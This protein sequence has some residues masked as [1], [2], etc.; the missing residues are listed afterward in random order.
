LVFLFSGISGY[1]SPVSIDKEQEQTEACVNCESYEKEGMVQAPAATI[2]KRDALRE[3]LHKARRDGN[4]DLFKELEAQLP[5]TP[6]EGESVG[7]IAVTKSSTYS[8]LGD[9]KVILKG[10]G[11]ANEAVFGTDIRV[12]P[13]FDSTENNQ[14]MVSDS[15]GNLYV[16]WQDNFFDYDYIQLYWSTDGGSTWIAYGYVDNTSAH[17]KTP[18]L[19]VGEGSTNNSLLLAYIVD[20]GVN[21]PYPEVATAPLTQGGFTIH[22]VPYYDFWEGYAKPVIWTD[23]IHWSGWFA[24]MTSE[25]IFEAAVNNI[26]VVFWRSTDFGATWT[27]PPLVPFG[28]TDP[29][30]WRDADGTYGTTLNRV[31]L[32][33]YQ[34]DDSNLY[35]VSSDD[36]GNTFN[37]AI[38]VG[39]ISPVPFNPV[40]P[41][42]EAAV[43]NN[44]VM[45]VFTKSFDGNDN[46][47]QT[48]SP[49]AG[50]TWPNP[51]WSLEGYTDINE[52]AADLTAN[53]GGGSWHLAYTRADWWV[54]YSQRP[55]DLSNFWQAVPDQVND[56]DWAS[57]AY[58]KKGIASNWST[59][60]PGIVWADYREGGA[61]G[62]YD[63]YFDTPCGGPI[64]RIISI[65]PD[66]LHFTSNEN[67]SNSTLAFNQ[68]EPIKNEANEKTKKSLIQVGDEV[69][70]DVNVENSF[71]ESGTVWEKTFSK[72]GASYV[73]IHFSS[74]DLPG[75]DNYVLISSPDGKV[76][77][78]YGGK[79]KVVQGGKEVLSTFWASYIPGDTA[80]VILHSS[81]S[82]EPG[83][84]AIDKVAY[85]KPQREINELLDGLDEAICGI[86]DKEWA[87]CYNGTT[88]YEKS[89][90]V[91]RLLINGTSACTGWLIGSQ[92]HLMTNNHCI[93]TQA[94]ADN[95]DYEFMAEG[96]TCATDCSGWFDCPGIVEASSGTL[97]Q[98]DAALDYTLILLPVNITSTYGYLQIR[99]VLPSV[100]ERIY[101]PQHPGAKGKQ[102]GVNDDQ[103]GGFCNVETTNETP[104]AG[105]PG[106]IGYFC[107]TEGGSSGSPVLAYSDHCVVALHHCADCP[108][109]G[110]PIPSIITDLGGNLPPDAICSGGGGD[111]FTISNLGNADLHV[112][113]MTKR[114]N[115]PWFDFN[116]KAPLTIPPGGSV[117]VTVTIDWNLINCNTTVDDRIIIESDDTNGNSP[118]PTGVFI[119]AEKTCA[120]DCTY[121][122][123]PASRNFDH[124]GGAGTVDV[125]TQAGCDWTA[126]SNNTWI[127]I[128]SG[129]SGAGS[130]TVNYSVAANPGPGSRTG[131][132]TVTG[133]AGQTLTHTV[134]QSAPQICEYS[135][136]PTSRNF[137]CT[138]GTG[139]INVTTQ[140]GCDWTAHS[141]NN[142]ITI[143]SGAGGAGNGTVNYT[144]DPNPDPNPP[145]TGTITITE[146]DGETL[147]HTVN[148]DQ[149]GEPN[150]WLVPEELTTSI[151]TDFTLE[152]H[153]DSGNQQ[154]GAYQFD[155][156]FTPTLIQVN[157]SIGTDGIEPGPDCSVAAVSLDN[158]NGK[159]T[160][161]GFNVT[162]TGPGAD[163]HCLTIHFTSQAPSEP[164]TTDVDLNVTTLVDPNGN[165]ILP[166]I[167]KG[168]V[169]T[170][171]TCIC[172]D[173]NGDGV[174]NIIDALLVARCSAGLPTPVDC[175]NLCA[176][177]N[178]DS[179]INI[180]D[181]L[182]IARHAA[183]LPG[184]WCDCN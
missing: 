109:R 30:A 173:I 43:N 131:T 94:T 87:P 12:G 110:V 122:I 169:V 100:G 138:G 158:I 96:A 111:T 120:P 37:T 51:L 146:D 148:Q 115:D 32:T 55:Q 117:Q 40:D 149:C 129:S 69:E 84:F 36:F 97:I 33:T 183:G 63:T 145:R 47:G 10:I 128:T 7:E 68:T 125:I 116:P 141:N 34:G 31:F 174:A 161:N 56:T 175:N 72:S 25:A 112:T 35:A 184:P 26:N 19:A 54:Y 24:Y 13:D 153:V 166:G 159:L 163:L 66:S 121:S 8:G 38:P 53:E 123:N 151:N 142:W 152:T 178:C 23:S 46:I 67:A 95:T 162:P 89:K 62:D 28:N 114:D 4:V 101:I 90:A 82:Q 133:D 176:D 165:P 119:T 2:P 73:S 181:A 76:K 74:F 132:I 44:N 140:A 150:V 106:D 65:S 182:L 14:T 22:S 5:K 29:Y 167:G 21:I 18:S 105:G 137:N 144:V 179:L 17:L 126:H 118:W 104:C 168:S 172:G 98:T 107:D 134:N 50:N 64:T 61:A 59:D 99:D 71:E 83:G 164:V 11:L 16:A 3:Q 171:T 136:N 9:L 93:S 170:I 6:V 127:T 155:I 92:N 180:I 60:C 39:L 15:N 78:K 52:F 80:V 48:Y 85:G 135:I 79:G 58:P 130:G 77:R 108:N 75:K 177:V 113:S 41:D 45:L 156:L 154:L 91:A 124:N 49:D 103:S 27:D 157:N 88:I 81:G 139:T 86:D 143:T 57:A 147:I 20:D 1:A 42:I 102:I 70:V 160:V